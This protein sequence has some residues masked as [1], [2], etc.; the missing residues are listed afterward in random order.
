MDEAHRQPITRENP[1]V[2]A[3]DLSNCDRE[4]IH[5]IQ[6]I[7]S[8]ACLLSVGVENKTV[9][10]C[11]DNTLQF[12]GWD[13]Q[14]VVG[15]PLTVFLPDFLL[16]RVYAHAEG[17]DFSEINPVT[18]PVTSASSQ[19]RIAI[20][21]LQGDTLM[22]EIEYGEGIEN[23][24]SLLNKMDRAIERIQ[25]I[26]V[27]QNLFQ[28]VTEEVK[29]VTGYDRVM[30]YQFDREYNG[31]VVAESLE[32]GMEPML[33]LH[34]PASDIPKQARDLYLSNRVRVIADVDDTLSFMYPPVHPHTKKPLTLS[35]CGARGVSPIHLEYLRNMGVQATLSV[36][37]VEDGKLWGLIACHHRKP[38]VLAY[39]VRNLIRFMGGIISGHLS[40]ERANHFKDTLLKNN[41]VHAQLVAHMSRERDIV[42]GLVASD[43][44]LL[45]YIPSSGAALL[46]EGQLATLGEV[47]PVAAIQEIAKWLVEEEKLLVYHTDSLSKEIPTIAA[48]A[49]D[50]AGVLATCLSAHPVE[51]IF[52]FR[53]AKSF[54][55][56]WGGNPDKA[57]LKREKGIRMSPR[58]SFAKWKQVVEGVSPPWKEHEVEAALILR[59]DIKEIILARFNELKKLNDELQR[60]YQE[61]E[62]FSYSV[63]H[64]L[65]SPLRGID[66]FANILLE[67]YAD[68]LDSYG[69][70]VIHTIVKGVAKMNTFINDT[71]TLS[72]LSEARL[73]L[74]EVK[75]DQVIRETLAEKSE[76]AAVPVEVIYLDEILPIQGD[77][78]M[79]RQLFDNLL[80]NAIK[81]S[82]PKGKSLL[83]ISCKKTEQ[84]I[85]YGIADNGIGF[86]MAYKEKIFEVFSRL[87]GEEEFSGTGIGLSIVKRIVERHKGYVDVESEEG[88]G[89][90]FF[91]HLPAS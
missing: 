28:V 39:R 29:Q 90:S 30:I 61:L 60:S 69:I 54:E 14:E 16:E 6:T 32:E 70:E 82:A 23:N 77:L 4:P 12:L 37:I 42:K 79:I 44:N 55:V 50:F 7:Q 21:H 76:L 40:L 45:S 81:Y 10:Q 64:D 83:Q 20:F 17:G 51:F 68:K 59:N 9:L 2:E 26:S 35:L 91:V 73:S 72:R 56:D 65:R 48:A 63:S 24:W 46:F 33:G 88:A 78:V 67:D 41:M 47:P 74:V 57:L 5:I 3:Y 34:Y 75:V 36:A 1:Y 31:S 62:S 43:Q 8:F 66:G 52:W 80:G 85:I 58:K 84:F 27:R 18:L 38:K 25:A 22:V 86:N 89:T 19:K 13:P 87:V 53:K 15:K 11:S 71:L 49:P